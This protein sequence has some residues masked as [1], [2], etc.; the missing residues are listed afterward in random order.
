MANFAV[1]ASA[2]TIE[3]ATKIM[4]L[5]ARE[6]EKK[7]DTLLRI[8]KVAENEAVK[9][10]HPE[11]E[12][13]LNAANATIAT[14][15]KQ[16]NGIV[17]G[18]DAQIL[19]LKK[20]LDEALEEKRN[21]LE[22]AKVQT[23]VA[24]EMQEEAKASITQATI[25]CEL[26]RNEAQEKIEAI[27]KDTAMQVEKANMERDQAIRER[28]DARTIAMEKVE[29]NDLLMKQLNTLENA[30]KEY[31]EQQEIN[32][33]KLEQLRRENNEVKE[34]INDLKREAVKAALEAELAIEKAAYSKEREMQAQLREADKENAKLSA[35]IEQLRDNAG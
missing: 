16:I 30:I 6:G 10:T 9:G 12:G 7:E 28:D 13:S 4:E 34:E 5:Y 29:N 21:A 11:L 31:K 27:Q 32:K 18:Q 19:E 24:L 23:D 33:K 8:L 17:A 25:D 14:L 1:A 20:R 15:I 3:L 22:N 35:M 2:E 26:A